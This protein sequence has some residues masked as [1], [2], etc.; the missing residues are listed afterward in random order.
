[1]FIRRRNQEIMNRRNR[2]RI[3]NR[4]HRRRIHTN[5]ANAFANLVTHL[6]F[7]ITNDSFANQLFNG[8]SFK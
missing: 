5:N 4:I 8:A 6:P 2:R 7:Q 3:V 1:M